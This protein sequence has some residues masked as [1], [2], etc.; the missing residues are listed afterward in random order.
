MKKYLRKRENRITVIFFL[1]TMITAISPLI[2]RY[3]INGTDLDYFLLRIESLKEGI[4]AGR[5]FIK[6]N[7]LFFGGA[8]YAATMFDSDILMHIPALLRVIGVDIG[9]SFHVYTAIIFILTY[10]SAFYCV[11]KMSLSKF[12]GTVAAILLTLCPYHM[13][14]MLFRTSSEGAAFIFLPLFIYGI[15]NVIYEDMDKPWVFGM[16][17]AGLIL[18]SPSLC[19]FAAVAA[20]IAM[21]FGIKRIIA[22]PRPF[23]KMCIVTALAALI[24][25]YQWLPMIEQLSSD[26]FHA[27]DNWKDIL[28]SS[29]SFSATVSTKFPSL[30]F[31]LPA[32]ALCRIFLSRKD[33]PILRF[34][35]Y[36]MIMAAVFAVGATDIMPWEHTA[37]F[38][39]FLQYPWRLFALSSVFLAMADAVVITL[40]LDRINGS[41]REIAAETA[42]LVIT[43]ICAQSALTHQN[44]TSLGYYDYSD[45][46]YSYKPFTVFESPDYLPASVTDASKLV[47]QSE[48]LVYDD[49]SL[50]R[51]ERKGAKI[52]ATVSESHE[53]ADVP[54]VYYKGYK[55]V[56]TDGGGNKEKLEITGDGENGL[57]RVELS[58]RKG[59]LKVVYGG[60][61]LQYVS[62]IISHI[63]I[64]LIFDLVYLKNKY[65]KKL[66]ERAAAAGANLGRIACV[67]IVA[68][69]ALSLSGCNV[70]VADLPDTAGFTDPN[71]VIDYLKNRNGIWDDEYEF[72]EENLVK[73]NYSK[74][75]YDKDGESYAVIID[76]SSGEQMI[77]AV[78][79]QEAEERT[80]EAASVVP[81]LYETLLKQEASDVLSRY[82]TDSLKD[83]IMNETDALLV[84]EVFPEIAKKNGIDKLAIEVGKNLLAIPEEKIED[85]IDKYNCAAVLAKAAYVLEWEQSEDA[86]KA[87]EK[88]FKDAESMEEAESEP[89]A[90][91]LWAAAELY[92][93]TGSKTY[94]S[95]VDAIAMDVIPEG[96]AYE[97]PGFFGLFAYLMSPYPTNYNVC[98]SMMNE[99]FDEANELIKKPIDSEF[100]DTRVDE[101]TPKRDEK[102]AERM[103][104]EAFLVTMTDYVSMSVEYKRFVQNRLNFIFGANLS[105]TDFTE[106]DRA[107]SD[108]PKMFI[109][110]GLCKNASGFQ[111]NQDSR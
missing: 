17:L 90:A 26:T 24:T 73:V 35:D 78:T 70:N 99:V 108:S 38:F 91:R 12:A 8:G 45:D 9:K 55:A 1:I 79:L 15:F 88:Y 111:Q 62:L 46:Y 19:A 16:G 72:T 85:T 101:K 53:Y 87:A 102:T 7:T 27:A 2:S 36:M 105:G 74:K 5:P 61:L 94:R 47:Q 63:F 23:I 56:L 40:F 96:F 22:A 10:L 50:G 21:L 57:C 42:L 103:H 109:Y 75:G 84:L 106:E 81:N 100:A 95:V 49:G 93:L 58:G 30:G 41:W 11:W 59:E 20:L 98:T 48:R 80:G 66:K 44:E 33:Y 110:S 39:G 3:C 82:R 97:E 4:F 6:V 77:E 34:S 65:K 69:S 29:I 67:L 54:F 13:D 76:E 18:T 64:F 92:R 43:V 89:V 104:E 37:K 71:E 25:A 86:L 28:D 68:A 52:I 60:T 51:F 107:L 83:R 32:L 31:I 14:D